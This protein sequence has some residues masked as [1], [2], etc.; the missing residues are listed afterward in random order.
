VNG[1]D[2]EVT[3]WEPKRRTA[4]AQANFMMR[5]MSDLGKVERDFCIDNAKVTSCKL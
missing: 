5:M 4:V 2:K 1:I 3:P